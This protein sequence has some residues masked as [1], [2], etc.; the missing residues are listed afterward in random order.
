[1]FRAGGCFLREG[2]DRP[3]ASSETGPLGILRMRRKGAS[4]QYAS[5]DRGGGL[6]PGPYATGC[7]IRAYRDVFTACPEV[8]TSVPNAKVMKPLDA[9]VGSIAAKENA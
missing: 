4:R 1:M 3:A 7:R 2:K 9:V 6:F 5:V 8:H